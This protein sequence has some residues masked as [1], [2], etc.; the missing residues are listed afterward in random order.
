MLASH[1]MEAA[2]SAGLTVMPQQGVLPRSA[3]ALVVRKYW[4]VKRS[5]DSVRPFRYGHER[6]GL[7]KV[8]GAAAFRPRLGNSFRHAGRCATSRFWAGTLVTKQIAGHEK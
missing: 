6:Y 1:R 4:V 2:S 3:F 5:S 8:C 7:P